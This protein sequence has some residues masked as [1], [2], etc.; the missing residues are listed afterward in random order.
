LTIYAIKFRYPESSADKFEAKEAVKHC[1][2]IRKA[3]R[4]A[5]GLSTT[6]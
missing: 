1:R 5:F 6:D 3:V 4:Q 2:L